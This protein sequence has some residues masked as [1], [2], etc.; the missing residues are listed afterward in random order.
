MKRLSYL[1]YSLLLAF[2]LTLGAVLLLLITTLRAAAQTP[3]GSAAELTLPQVIELT[4]AQSSV[5]KQAQTNRETSLWQY[6]SF[7]ADYKPQ[8]ALEGTLPNYSRTITP[9]TQQ[10]GSTA[11]RYVRINNSYLGTTVSQNIGPTGGTVTVGSY[12]QR[13]DNFEGAGQRLYNSNPISLGLVQP[14][15]RFNTLAWAKRIEPLRFEESQRQFVEERETIARRVTELYFDVLLQ[16][17]NADVARQNREVSQDMLRMGREKN[18]LGRISEND[19]L[20]LEQN[21][22]NAQQAEV[23]ASV[24]AQTAALQL[25]GYTGL[26]VDVARPLAVPAAASSLTINPD[27]ALAHARQYRREPLSYQRRLLEAERG[28]AQAKGTT[29]LQADLTASFGLTSSADNLPNSYQN[30]N[31]QQQVR[32]GFTMPLVD[33]GKTRATV[34]TAELTRQQVKHTVE[35]EQM[36]F[37]QSVLAQAAQLSGLNQ[38]RALAARADSLAQ[39]R[40]DIT[41]ATYQVGRLSLTDLNIAQQDKDR[42]KRAYIAALRACWVAYYQLRSLTLYDYERQQPLL[43]AQ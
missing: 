41:R 14:I 9:V 20:L 13:F 37:E 42:A 6:R 17:V 38:Q 1:L 3:A 10:D 35:Q 33:W 11:F 16:Q 8:L 28:V 24:D 19:L 18:K 27:E 43:A 15:G 5:A 23:Q 12:L 32:L 26:T 7:R 25:K 2:L 40:Y 29:G 4:L 22:L 21:L 31:N 36:T 30:P 39:R 34:K